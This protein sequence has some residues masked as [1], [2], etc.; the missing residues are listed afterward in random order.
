ML[1]LTDVLD[2]KGGDV[3]QAESTA[4]V[5]EAAQIMRSADVGSV[6][7]MKQRRLVGILSQRDLVRRVLANHLGA[8][9]TRVGEVMTR[10]VVSAAPRL[11]AVEAVDIMTTRRQRYLPVG[12][13]AHIVGVV[14]LGDI[15]HCAT[16]RL[17][18][19]V[20]EL[21]EFLSHSHKVTEV[22]GLAVRPARDLPPGD[23]GE[24][25]SDGF[26]G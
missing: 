2:A 5:R 9:E 19:D 12:D 16:H 18:R 1:T 13:P 10:E 25:W 15:M 26:G 20:R 14:S 4:S 3:A 8:E 6:L 24:F 7:V 17:G 11:S 21:V 23:N 22:D